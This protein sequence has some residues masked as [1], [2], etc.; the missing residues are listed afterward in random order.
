[1]AG[2]HSTTLM[3]SWLVAIPSLALKSSYDYGSH[4]WENGLI[5]LYK[6]END[7]IEGINKYFD[8]EKV[9][10]ISTEI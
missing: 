9:K 7:L 8:K 2:T 5:E 6:N 3:E 1:M 4:L 10:S